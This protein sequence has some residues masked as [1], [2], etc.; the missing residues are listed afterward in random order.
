LPLPGLE[1][2]INNPNQN[3]IGEIYIKGD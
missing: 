1:I 2:K 3:G